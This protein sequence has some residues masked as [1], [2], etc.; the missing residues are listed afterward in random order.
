MASVL[1]L[2]ACT[3][4]PDF[5]PPAPPQTASYAKEPFARTTGDASVAEGEPQAFVRDGDIPAGWW[6]L[7][8]SPALD[9]LVRQAI[10]DNPNLQAAQSALKAAMEDVKAQAGAYYPSVTGGLGI[11]RNRNSAQ[12]SPSLSSPIFLFN[13]Y[14]AQLGANWTLDIWGADKRQVE[15]LSALAEA[16]HYQLESTYVALA[17]NVV[18]AAVEEASL[19]QQVAVTR[20]MLAAEKQILEIEQRQKDLGQISGADLVTQDVAVA[21]TEEALPP[22]EKQ[23]AQARDLLA[24]LAG[25]LPADGIAQTFTL[26]SFTLP[27]ELPVSLP[28]KLVGQ[29]PDI[30][31]AEANLH[32]AS[33]ELGVAIANMLPTL[34]LTAADGTVG[35]ELGQL[36]AAG[37]G[38]WS[39]GAGLTQPL[40]DG[41]TLLHKSRAA[42]AMLEEMGAQYRATV[43]A[44][45]QNVAD[46]L[47]AVQ[48]DGDNLKAAAAA[49]NAAERQFS[50][51]RT[52][53]G[54][55][56]IDRLSLLTA[57]QSYFQ[58]RL[59]LA[60]AQ[61]GRL[62]DT[63]ALFQALGGGWWH[64][65]DDIQAQK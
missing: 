17:A 26:G 60:Q 9:S 16:Q 42:R 65:T 44:A 54:L 29:R 34:T 61:A 14:Q 27:V 37:N 59:A 30:R 1:L 22:L 19:R 46:G 12:L 4:G 13:L 11:S 57:E 53:L 10:A 5:K 2:A 6:S 62:A 47:H 18:A 15:A 32:A 38:F 51:A 49:A 24:A 43:I 7:F 3:V 8:R 45:L 39:I 25:R 35:T 36:F 41:G 31:I 40:F 63:A 23:L 48:S 28:A 20:D 64:R 33:A 21:Q 58:A 55:G 52:E 50:I 56:Q